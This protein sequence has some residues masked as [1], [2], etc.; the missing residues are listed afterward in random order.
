MDRLRS[1]F[2]GMFDGVWLV[3]DDG[4]T[5]YANAAMAGLLGST[6]EAMRGRPL[7]D[8]LDKSL[9]A[10][11]DAFLARQRVQAGERMELTL[12]RDDGTDLFGIVAGSPLTTSDGRFIGTML[13]F[14]D[15]TGKHAMD[16][17]M[18][19]NQRMEAIGQFAGGIA[20]D[21]NNL[22][23][24]IRG[25]A[26]LARMSLPQDDPI[27]AD[28]DQ[29]I[30]GAQR[31]AAITRKLLAFT[32]R[33]VL[34]PADIDPA[35]VITDLLPILEVLLGDDVEI[36]LRFATEHGWVRVD[37]T[38]L[39]QVIVN[40]AVNARDSMPKGGALV[41]AVQDVAPTDSDRPD[42]DLTA[43]PFVRI[44]VVDTGTGMDEA[45]KARIFDPFFT[46]KAPGQGTG[47]GLSTVFKIVAQSEG[48]I[49]VETTLGQGSTFNVD[50]PR[51][52]RAVAARIQTGDAPLRASGVVLLVEDE[53]S[54]RES[55]RRGLEIAGYKVLAAAGGAEA[56][57]ASERWDEQIDVLVT[58]ISMPGIRG[59]ALAVQLKETRPGIEVVFISG[60]G[61]DNVD[62]GAE[63]GVAG[64]F[65]P[66][67]FGMEALARAV[68][69]AVAR[70]AN[71]EGRTAPEA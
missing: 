43:G 40:L 24:A 57:R 23:T 33:Q 42:P 62:P 38:Q 53:P 27:R 14:S 34:V 66:K 25:Y 69:R 3:G 52:E 67:P 16:A 37:P 48:Q 7:T 11:A 30:A 21:F 35:Q 39:E 58:D 36:E 54:V 32:R 60:S 18:V 50:L 13:N 49:Q 63:S 31:A 45:T 51:V 19:Q 61:G 10:G 12:R 68:G 6:A 22:L 2:D 1:I 56:I 59:T 64:E 8:F 70:G 9:W 4:R 41:I 28:L 71:V 20:H 55:V 17:Q 5:T 46:T 65:L 47:L 29:V 44:S 15:V 26:E